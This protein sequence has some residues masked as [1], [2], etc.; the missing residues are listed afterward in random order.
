MINKKEKE[1]KI[2]ATVDSYDSVLSPVITEK[3]TMA[4]QYNQ[5]TFKVS[6]NSSK[7]NIKKAVERIFGVQVIGINTIRVKGKLK[8]FKGKI[9]K[10]PA[11]KKAIVTLKEGDTIDITQN[12]Q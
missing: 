7:P 3:A 1:K 5:V 2:D 8:K 9:G 12:I 4:S 6:I 11:F 10:T